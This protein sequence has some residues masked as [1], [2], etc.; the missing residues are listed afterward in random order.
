VGRLERAIDPV[1]SLAGRGMAQT[2]SRAD[3]SAARRGKKKARVNPIALDILILC[4][5]LAIRIPVYG[6]SDDFLL[7]RGVDQHI[8]FDKTA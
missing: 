4:A 1:R 6:S 8:V 2:E 7:H 5:V 3:F